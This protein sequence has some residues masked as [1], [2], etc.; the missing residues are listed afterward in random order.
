MQVLRY[1]AKEKFLIFSTSQTT[2]VYIRDA[3][4]LIGVK[5]MGFS[6]NNTPRQREHMVMTFETSDV[7]RVFLMEL[8]YGARGLYAISGVHARC[9][10]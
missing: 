5:S 7:H 3:L 2:L 4:N 9:L 1:S 6:Q 8:K 10:C